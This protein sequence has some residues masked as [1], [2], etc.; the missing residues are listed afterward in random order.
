MFHNRNV[1]VFRFLLIGISNTGLDA[2]ATQDC[3]FFR[4]VDRYPGDRQCSRNHA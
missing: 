3:H 4:F 1:N 2:D